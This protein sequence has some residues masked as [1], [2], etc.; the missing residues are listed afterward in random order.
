MIVFLRRH[1]QAFLKLNLSFFISSEIEPYFA[2]IVSKLSFVSFLYIAN[3]SSKET[4]YN[5]PLSKYSISA[6][7]T[8]EGTLK[9]I[10]N[11]QIPCILS[12]KDQR[13]LSHPLCKCLSFQHK[14]SR[15]RLFCPYN[16]SFSKAG[17]SWANRLHKKFQLFHQANSFKTL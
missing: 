9:P 14:R 2:S 17:Q 7:S 8:G 11:I 6:R 5:V 10:I 16:P 13:I 1:L 4:T 12:S 3:S 15:H